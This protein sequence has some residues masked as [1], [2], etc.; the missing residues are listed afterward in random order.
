MIGVMSS[1]AMVTLTLC[2]SITPS[3]TRM[4]RVSVIEILIASLLAWAT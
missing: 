3:M 1:T 4:V 2:I